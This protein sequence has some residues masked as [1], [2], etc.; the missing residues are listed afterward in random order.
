MEFWKELILHLGGAV[1]IAVVFLAF[2]KS[3]IQKWLE[4][5]MNTASDKSIAKF[6]NSLQR[7]TMAYEMLLQKEFG[8]YEAAAKFTS[9][10]IVDIQDYTFYSGCSE[11]QPGQYNIGK[12]KEVALRI[13]EGIKHFKG[14][15]LLAHTY[16]PDNIN[17]AST[18]LI[19]Q[20]QTVLP[21]MHETIDKAISGNS[22]MDII[23]NMRKQED[24][25]LQCCAVLNSQIQVHLR[26]LSKE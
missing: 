13:I 14:E 20:V 2:V 4:N 3:L 7:K 9:S 1:G 23:T 8:F 10:L 21:V 25:I 15:S 19:S 12:A 11:E 18:Q 24:S 16:I 22:S 6:S 17:Q 5:I 26:A